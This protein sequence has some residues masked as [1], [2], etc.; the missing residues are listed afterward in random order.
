VGVEDGVD[1]AGDS[2]LAAAAGGGGS[3]APAAALLEHELAADASTASAS[4]M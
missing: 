4:T 2:E 3:A 1:G